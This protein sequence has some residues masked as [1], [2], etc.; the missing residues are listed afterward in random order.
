MKIRFSIGT[1]AAGVALMMTAAGVLAS[2]HDQASAQASAAAKKDHVRGTVARV[3]GEQLTVTT[4]SGPVV[5]RLTPNTGYDTAVASDRS[6]I[7]DGSYVGITSVT[8]PDGSQH[9]VEVH[10]FPEAMRGTGEGS[11]AWDLPAT[12]GAASRMTN[13]KVAAS[14]MT[15][16]TVSRSPASSASK[17]TSKMTNGTVAKAQDGGALT[18]R[19]NA[20][21]ASGAQVITIP[22]GIPIVAI[23]P[24][25]RANVVP[26]V[27]VFI[28]ASR[29]ADGA[30]TAEKVRTGKNGLVPPM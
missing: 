27:H 17:A 11:Y 24:G 30:L 23:E 25:A 22:P 8:Q 10:L 20:D 18:V 14:K 29:A 28:I 1:T 4:A 12:H 26:G 16:G 7:N 21:G 3:D 6:H 5:V 2:A 19:Y 15:N 9:A 13:G